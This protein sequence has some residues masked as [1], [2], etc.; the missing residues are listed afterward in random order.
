MIADDYIAINRERNE[1]TDERTND[2]NEPKR[3]IAFVPK[4][5]KRNQRATRKVQF[6][7]DL[8]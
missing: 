6:A 7:N 1:W 8:S 4:E 3:K 5:T 2:G